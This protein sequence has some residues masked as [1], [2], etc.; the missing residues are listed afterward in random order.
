MKTLCKAYEN[1]WFITLENPHICVCTKYSFSWAQCS[2]KQCKKHPHQGGSFHVTFTKLF[3]ESLSK[4][5]NKMVFSGN[6]LT[7]SS[8]LESKHDSSHQDFSLFSWVT[9]PGF[10]LKVSNQG[11]LHIRA[12]VG[13]QYRCHDGFW[14]HYIYIRFELHLY[15]HYN[16]NKI[17]GHD[18]LSWSNVATKNLLVMAD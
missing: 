2:P 15:S 4:P 3:W 18:L 13:P 10:Y 12:L 7:R 11:M 14:V 6:I 5:L 8:F 16:T 17:W 1:H 9:L